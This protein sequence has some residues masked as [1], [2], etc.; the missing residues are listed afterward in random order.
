MFL[1]CAARQDVQQIQNFIHR[2]LALNLKQALNPGGG[3]LADRP[4][5]KDPN[6][7]S[8]YHHKVLIYSCH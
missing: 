4:F 7:H 6:I 5:R 3:A 2:T 1:Q 8:D